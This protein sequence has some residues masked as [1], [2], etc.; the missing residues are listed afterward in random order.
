M[1]TNIWPYWNPTLDL[2]WILMLTNIRPYW[3]PTLYICVDIHTRYYEWKNKNNYRNLWITNWQIAK[4]DGYWKILY[5]PDT[6]LYQ[7]AITLANVTIQFSLI[8]SNGPSWFAHH[9]NE[10]FKTLVIHNINSFIYRTL[11]R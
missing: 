10:K 6:W 1:L 3:N 5:L 11:L 7:W 9:Q 2:R 8:Q 4:T